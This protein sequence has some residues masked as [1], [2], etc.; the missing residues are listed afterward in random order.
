[1]QK[2]EAVKRELFHFFA[3]LN[4]YRIAV[5]LEAESHLSPT[6]WFLTENESGKSSIATKGAMLFNITVVS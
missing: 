2:G 6:A 3:M 4:Q 1:M 5:V